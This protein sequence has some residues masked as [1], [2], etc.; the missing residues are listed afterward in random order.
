MLIM[1]KKGIIYKLQKEL[2]FV[3]AQEK[4]YK[5]KA[6]GIFRDKNIK[7]VVGDNVEIT[8]LSE[9]EAI[10]DNVLERSSL[11]IRPPVAN[12]NQI[13]LVLTLKSPNLNYVLV[14]KYL[15]MLE[16]FGLKVTIIFNKIDLIDE[17][18]LL[19]L[20]EE[21]EKTNYDVFFTSTINKSGIDDIK[22][23]IKGKITAL[24]GPSGVGKSSLINL[25]SDKEKIAQTGN[26]SAKTQRGKHTT[27]HTELFEIF[28]GAFILDTP[29]FSSLDLSFINDE[30]E[31]RNFYPEFV[32]HQSKCKFQN[33]QHIKE[34]KC[35]VK[36][37]L[38]N[39]EIS[40]IRYENYLLIREEIKKNRR[41]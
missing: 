31:I 30:N 3:L 27:R 37:A 22:K 6:R 15:I 10:I 17:D 24:A 38:E 4:S 12:V 40:R 25:I 19:A 36:E 28:E 23:Q 16:H 32:A 33:C 14:D 9:D 11:L 41:Y 26:I 29:G 2:Y 1:T 34:P 7:P 18:E 8:I 39:N 21:Y 5:C 20:K 35:A 13:L